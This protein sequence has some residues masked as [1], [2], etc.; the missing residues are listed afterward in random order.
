MPSEKEIHTLSGAAVPLQHPQ[1]LQIF[2]NL[3]ISPSNYFHFPVPPR[4]PAFHTHTQHHHHVNLSNLG[5]LI[6]KNIL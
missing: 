6:P 5:E 3:M 2:L 1:A 4:P